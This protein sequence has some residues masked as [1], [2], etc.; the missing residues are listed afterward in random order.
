VPQLGWTLGYPLVAGVIFA[1]LSALFRA[2][3][4][5]RRLWDQHWT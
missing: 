2:F 3:Q 4:R 5:P 1:S